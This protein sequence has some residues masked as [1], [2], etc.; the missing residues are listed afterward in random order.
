MRHSHYPNLVAWLRHSEPS[1]LR[2][3]AG[4]GNECYILHF[5][6]QYATLNEFHT[7]PPKDKESYPFGFLEPSRNKE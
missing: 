4:S 3:F 1:A 2:K 7:C 5:L 6:D